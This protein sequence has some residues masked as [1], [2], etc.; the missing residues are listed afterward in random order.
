[1]ETDFLLLLQALRIAQQREKS[2]D[3]FEKHRLALLKR[4]K[5][6]KPGL[7]GGIFSYQNSQF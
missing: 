6:V 5:Q 3:D 1:L 4:R 7:P 2:R